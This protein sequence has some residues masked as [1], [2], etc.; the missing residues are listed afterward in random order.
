MENVEFQTHSMIRPGL[1]RASSLWQAGAG[2]LWMV[3][4]G[5]WVRVGGGGRGGPVGGWGV[6]YSTVAG[7]T[8]KLRKWKEAGVRLTPVILALAGLRQ[9]DCFWP[10]RVFI[11]FFVSEY[12]LTC[13][14]TM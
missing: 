8:R 11:L 6:Y 7:E 1:G 3:S 14:V 5:R 10:G 4:W 9:E 12:L 2:F 13:M